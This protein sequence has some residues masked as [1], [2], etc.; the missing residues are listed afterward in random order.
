MRVSDQAVMEAIRAKRKVLTTH[1]A[2]GSGAAESAAMRTSLKAAYAVDQPVAAMRVA[3]AD[4]GVA[5]VTLIHPDGRTESRALNVGDLLEI[6]VPVHIDGVL[7]ADLR[8]ERELLSALRG[9][10]AAVDGSVAGADP[11]P[12]NAHLE[13]RLNRIADA[14]RFIARNHGTTGSTTPTGS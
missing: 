12:L 13:A 4:N 1:P 2:P 5:D 6:S 11:P 3:G 7:V 14:V 8:H 9:F 10:S